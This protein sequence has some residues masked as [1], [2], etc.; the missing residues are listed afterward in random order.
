MNNEF[1][2]VVSDVPDQLEYFNSNVDINSSVCLTNLTLV[3][4]HCLVDIPSYGNTKW[5]SDQIDLKMEEISF[6][7]EHFIL[8]RDVASESEKILRMILR[9]DVSH[10][11]YRLLLYSPFSIVNYTELK[12]EFQ[13]GNSRMF[14]STSQ[15]PVLVCT[16]KFESE[17]NRNGQFRLYNVE[18]DIT[19]TNWSK[20]FSLDAI[21]SIDM[22]SCQTANDRTYMMIP[23]WLRNLKNCF[24]RIRYAHNHVTS[25]PFPI[26][27][28]RQIRL[29]MN[30]SEYPLISV[31]IKHDHLNGIKV[32]FED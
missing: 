18:E 3:D 7:Y 19:M 6:R 15:T 10:V 29:P 32:M 5:I 2:H 27:E 31:N 30:Y 22:I 17:D 21:K 28:E 8:F 1:S 12:I 4:V 20:K 13:I 14:I 25:D 16:E 9:V 26:D 11:P 24:T 23:L